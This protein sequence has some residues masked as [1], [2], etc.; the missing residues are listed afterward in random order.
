MVGMTDNTIL[1]LGF[2]RTDDGDWTTGLDDGQVDPD[3]WKKTGVVS[4]REKAAKYGCK[5]GRLPVAVYWYQKF[6]EDKPGYMPS[7][8]SMPRCPWKWAV[9]G[10]KVAMRGHQQVVESVALQPD[11]R[12]FVSVSKDSTARF[13]D[14]NDQKMIDCRYI[15]KP[16]RSATFWSMNTK[17]AVVANAEISDKKCTIFA[18]GHDDG[19]FSVWHTD[20]TAAEAA[21]QDDDE[22]G[23]PLYDP[24]DAFGGIHLLCSNP[25]PRPA[26]PL[27]KG[28]KPS[29]Q[30]FS[31]KFSPNGQYFAVTLG[32]NC[33]DIYKHEIRLVESQTERSVMKEKAKQKALGY[34][35]EEIER[36]KALPYK[37]VGCCNDHSSA[38][39]HIDFDSESL[40]M[41]TTSQSR[42]LL[43]AF[44][45]SGKQCMKTEELSKKKWQTTNCVLGWSVKSIW[46]RGSNG[47]DVN[48]V[49]RTSTKMPPWA[50]CH[51]GNRPSPY[52]YPE[53]VMPN[54][55]SEPTD[56]FKTNNYPGEGKLSSWG[57]Y[58]CAT[59]DDNGKIKLF[60]W[61]AFGF[62]QA[63]RAY[64]GHGSHV[65]Q[66]RFSY[67]DDY[68]ISAGGS[69]MSLFQWRHVIPNKIYVQNLPDE[70]D[71][72]GDFKVSTSDL[73][74]YLEDYFSRFLKINRKS[75]VNRTP[76]G[77]L[78]KDFSEALSFIGGL[79]PKQ[80]RRIKNTCY[81]HAAAWKGLSEE[82]EKHVPDRQIVSISIFNSG[83]AWQDQYFPSKK[84]GCKITCRW[85]CVVFKSYDDVE[86]VVDLY[87]ASN[88][89][90]YGKLFED[91]L[92]HLH[93]LYIEDKDST[94]GE[95]DKEKE[96]NREAPAVNTRR[97]KERNPATGEKI[98]R[99][100][101]PVDE[102]SPLKYSAECKNGLKPHF[103]C[104]TPYD[105]S[106]SAIGTI[107]HDSMTRIAE[108]DEM[109]K[110][111]SSVSS[112][113]SSPSCHHAHFCATHTKCLLR[114]PI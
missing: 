105:P 106:E 66:V 112:F 35:D 104:I 57:H 7:G 9:I 77:K 108:S 26:P 33:V 83:A 71:E 68:L 36:Q 5:A 61:P 24:E 42:E 60:R 2:R 63:Y 76:D 40:Y 72:Q 102:N 93:P 113:A 84:D 53:G 82:D 21:N 49:D 16:A 65:M 78:E 18:I 110:K 50:P 67:D 94:A 46:A 48:T 107:V 75:E 54:G 87:G 44:V 13:F 28:R 111:L 59:G 52:P 3:F 80:Q 41:R 45:P 91:Q 27:E 95:G 114:T 99:K 92:L 62:K 55:S 30:A 79:S 38:V 43:F 64:L 85:A 19:S 58:V 39:E 69:D 51:G 17:G 101:N 11:E 14:I 81:N 29:E 8:A 56:Q 22:E 86:D 47:S 98:V 25:L 103:L 6:E 74:E 70:I 88:V 1:L 97:S 12:I 100:W 90:S 4:Y 10:K 23:D 37:R 34:G 15:Y 20:K 89:L 73:K 31:V 32:D 96:Y 109:K